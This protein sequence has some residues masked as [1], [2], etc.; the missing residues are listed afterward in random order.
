MLILT[1]TFWRKFFLALSKIWEE[2]DGRTK[3]SQESYAYAGS[4]VRL[5]DS[6]VMVSE[7]RAGAF[8]CSFPVQHKILRL[9]LHV[10]GPP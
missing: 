5:L 10:R 9:G 2:K 7:A 4:V 6:Q 1:C 3:L 8:Y